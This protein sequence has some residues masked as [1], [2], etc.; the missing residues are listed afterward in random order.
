[1]L[2]DSAELSIVQP[3]AKRLFYVA[4]NRTSVLST[5][6]TELQH[7]QTFCIQYEYY[8]QNSKLLILS[9]I[10]FYKFQ[11][12]TFE[13]LLSLKVWSTKYYCQ[14]HYNTVKQRSIGQVCPK[15]VATEWGYK[16]VKS[17]V[18]TQL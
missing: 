7:L 6:A 15:E 13:L 8:F 14:G 3:V 17:Q 11:V 18:D 10:F 9:K 2:P 12:L 5:G 4:R 16:L 1:M